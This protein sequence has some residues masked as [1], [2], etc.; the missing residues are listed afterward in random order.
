MALVCSH[1]KL[2]KLCSD[3]FQFMQCPSFSNDFARSSILSHC[4]LHIDARRGKLNIFLFFTTIEYLTLTCL[5]TYCMLNVQ[6]ITWNDICVHR[7]RVIA[8]PGE[9]DSISIEHRHPI[10]NSNSL[11]V[12]LQ[13]FQS[14]TFHPHYLLHPFCKQS[15]FCFI[16]YLVHS[17]LI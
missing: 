12:C 14:C 7:I 9:I 8:K 10:I 2:F 15:A 1:K 17:F 11:H 6:C 3:T 13:L 5:C 16:H 4:I